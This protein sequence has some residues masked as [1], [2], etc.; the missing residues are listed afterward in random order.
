MSYTIIYN[1]A[2]IRI[3]DKRVLPILEIGDSNLYE[4][5]GRGNKRVRNWSN[6]YSFTKG[7]IIIDENILIEN[8]DGINTKY[9]EQYREPDRE[10]YDPDRFGYFSGIKLY[11][12]R[13]NGNTFKA[14]RSYFVNGCK[15]ALTVEQ[16]A[17]ND[18]YFNVYVYVYDTNPITDAGLEIKPYVYPKTT[19]ELVNT[20][21]EYTE[22]YKDVRDKCTIYV[23]LLGAYNLKRLRARTRKEK[24]LVEIPFYFVLV[25]SQGHYLYKKTK[26]G[27]RYTWHVNSQSKIFETEKAAA[28]YL[29]KYPL[30]LSDFKIKKIK[31]PIYIYKPKKLK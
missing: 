28:K 18:I 9:A 19:E 1:R 7:K 24:E 23:G 20:I 13:W 16:Y 4:A 2:F 15:T 30:I 8:I 5:N 11:G 29:L 25:N 21:N 14:F 26:Y 12:R 22:Y 17:E 3:D 6:V 31:E 27:Y 10:S